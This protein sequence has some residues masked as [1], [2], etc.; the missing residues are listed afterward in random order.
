MKNHNIEDLILERFPYVKPFKVIAF[1]NKGGLEVEIYK[2]QL[3]FNNNF[4]ELIQIISTI[5]SYC[6]SINNKK[7]NISAFLGKKMRIRKHNFMQ[8]LDKSITASVMPII[9]NKKDVR[10]VINLFSEE[11]LIYSFELDYTV[12]SKR[13]F[14]KIFNNH[15]VSDHNTVVD[16]INRIPSVKN[17][18]ID[19]WNFV[20]LIDKF[21]KDHCLG[22]FQNYPIVPSVRILDCLIKSIKNWMKHIISLTDRLIIVD[23]VEMF[24]NKAMPIERIYHSHITQ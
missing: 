16:D 10:S 12:F 1:S 13:V 17:N 21:T 9:N 19:E 14:E 11:N 24:L 6:V 15:Y 22:H 18:Y 20:A 4:G 8:L 3:Y 23:S 2:N 5:G 7:Q